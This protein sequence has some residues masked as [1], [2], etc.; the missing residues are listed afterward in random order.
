MI[1]EILEVVFRL[2]LGQL[3]ENKTLK[4]IDKIFKLAQDLI[5]SNKYQRDEVRVFKLYHIL[6]QAYM[7]SRQYLSID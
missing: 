3:I 5:L 2:H 1:F 7:N 4:D 6:R